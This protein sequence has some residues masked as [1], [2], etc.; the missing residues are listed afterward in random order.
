MVVD[1]WVGVQRGF[2]GQLPILYPTAY[3]LLTEY[4][5]RL[6]LIN[7]HPHPHPHSHSRQPQTQRR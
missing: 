5:L 2:S 6:R 4:S 3:M 1:V 7:P